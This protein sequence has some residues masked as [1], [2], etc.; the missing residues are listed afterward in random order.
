MTR[1]ISAEVAEL[2]RVAE[3]RLLVQHSDHDG[4]TILDRGQVEALIPHRDPFLLI[5]RVV[6]LNLE[7]GVIVAEFDL[8]RAE[9]V[10]AGHFPEYPVYPGVLQ[11][12]A[13]GQVG[14]VLYM[15]KTGESALANVALTHVLGARFMKPVLPGGS[16]QIVSQVI[17]D[18]LFFTIVGQCIR[19]GE[20]CSVAALSG[21]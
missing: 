1:E 15:M 14:I 10:F 20:I 16:L 11:I 18:G 12:E 19:D 13:I 9:N 6:D 21:M 7:K 4:V 8:R 17:E 3:K 5:D 2:L